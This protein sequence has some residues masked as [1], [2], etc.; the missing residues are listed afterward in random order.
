MQPFLT[1][2]TWSTRLD[3]Q[4]G[5]QVPLSDIDYV[6]LNK[7]YIYVNNEELNEFWIKT[8]RENVTQ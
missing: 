3:V 2:G 1:K 7:P 4:D 6:R 5:N 8:L